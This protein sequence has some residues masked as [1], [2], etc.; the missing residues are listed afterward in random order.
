[1][2]SI[3]LN[4]IILVIFLKT[5]NV[6]SEQSIFNVNNIEVVKKANI[7]HKELANQAIKKG[8]NEL[9]NK[10][11]IDK[12]IVKIS[13]ISF[14]E[15][16]Q[17]VSYYQV[18]EDDKNQEEK[19]ITFN[20]FFDKNKLYEVFYERGISYSE[21]VNKEIYLLP[22][23]ITKD[24]IHIFNQ[25]YYYENW[26]E[27]NDNKLLEFILP[28]EN[29]EIIRN[30]SL[31][32][33]NLEDIKL[34]NLFK[35]YPNKNLALVVIDEN[36]FKVQKIYLKTV[37]LGKSVDKNLIL[38]QNNLS[39]QEFNEKI[40]NT[41][42]N[43]ITN[44]VKTQNLVDISTPSFLNA[45]L[46]LNK[47]NNLLELYKRLKNI[48]LIDNVYVQK[49]NNQYVL[50]KIKYLGKLDKIINQLKNENILLKLSGESWSLKII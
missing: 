31:N 44:I 23:L 16:K 12:D 48:E 27:K 35:E 33:E 36:N 40:I 21:I 13:K 3:K 17:L 25:N 32:I 38:K 28:L 26:T 2:K 39:K 42:S 9:I 50:L 37:I 22:I 10:I 19:K 49:Y 11:L 7:S 1:M 46:L 4:F 5:G 47:K 41:T 6:L 24:Q 43:L 20:I 15:I 14:S 30:L 29:I 18:F 34:N 45:K 8:F